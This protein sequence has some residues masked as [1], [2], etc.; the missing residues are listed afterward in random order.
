[1]AETLS[2]DSFI[3]EFESQ[4]EEEEAGSMTAA[5]RFKDLEEWSSMHALV[6]NLSFDDQYGITLT[7]EE[8]RQAETIGD[9]FRLINEKEA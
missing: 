2:L 7:S 4:F 5:T 6:V 8:F 3:A 9:L 1:M